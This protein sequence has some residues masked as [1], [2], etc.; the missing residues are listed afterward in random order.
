MDQEKLPS[1]HNS[2][3]KPHLEVLTSG[4]YE[5]LQETDTKTDDLMIKLYL[6]IVKIFVLDTYFCFTRGTNILKFEMGTSMG[7][8]QNPRYTK[9]EVF[10]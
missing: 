4:T 1:W 3:Q 10:H 6:G 2:P 7:R 8:L 5:D 9:N